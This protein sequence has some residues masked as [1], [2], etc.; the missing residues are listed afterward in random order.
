MYNS[1]KKNLVG[2]QLLILIGPLIFFLAEK[3]MTMS[4]NPRDY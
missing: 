1:L 3:P 4:S 2:T